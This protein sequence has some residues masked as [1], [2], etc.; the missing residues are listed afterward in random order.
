MEPHKGITMIPRIIHYCWFG[1]GALPELA[2]KCI[3]SWQVFCPDYQMKIWNEQTFDIN[4]NVYVK[5]AYFSKK[6]AFVTDYVRLW[7]LNT[8]GGIYMDT[9]VEVLKPLDNL[10]HFPAFSGFEDSSHI[11]TGIIGSTPHGVWIQQM[12]KYYDNKHFLN[13]DGSFDL[14]TNVITI[15]KLMKENGFRLDDTLQNYKNMVTIF[16]HDYFCPKDYYTEK[17]KITPNTYTI[18]HFSKSWCATE[19]FWQRLLRRHP[20]LNSFIHLPN[21]I[22][23]M[24]LGSY[25]FKLKSIIKGSK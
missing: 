21:R 25:Y 17:I 4:S 19:T 6:Y 9:D 22:G 8:W 2:Q 3:T 16:P 23:K 10:L 15:T 18:H 7:A 20:L 11:P 24:L 13:P 5:E 12:L 14:T 1:G